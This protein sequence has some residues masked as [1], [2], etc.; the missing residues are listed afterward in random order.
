MSCGFCHEDLSGATCT[1]TCSHVIHTACLLKKMMIDTPVYF[2]CS[3]CGQVLLNQEENPVG[4]QENVSDHED[5]PGQDPL[6]AVNLFQTNTDFR[7]DIKIFYKH[8]KVVSKTSRLF[9]KHVAE[10]RR[11]FKLAVEPL[12]Q[13]IKELQKQ[14]VKDIY[15]SE[16]RKESLK[17]YRKG[18]AIRKKILEK[19]KEHHL[20]SFHFRRL[21]QIEGM[22]NFGS[23]YQTFRYRNRYHRY[24]FGLYVRII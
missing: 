23:L 7:N 4:F 22:K 24:K 18:V 14:K 8:L 12:K 9:W 1:L 3:V 11:N 2:N 16:Q 10:E 6:T 20:E 21:D 15:S 13:S 5:I 19:Y 17:Q